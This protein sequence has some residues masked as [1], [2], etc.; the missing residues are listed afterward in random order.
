VRGNQAGESP[1]SCA[2]WL[3]RG[4]LKKEKDQ[5]YHQGRNTQQV[6]RADEAGMLLSLR[7]IA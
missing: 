3:G 4:S 7:L 5:G 6:D 1:F 2:K